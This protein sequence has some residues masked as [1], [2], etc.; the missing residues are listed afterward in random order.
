M[1]LSYL[2]FFRSLRTE[3]KQFAVIG[4]GR[5]GRAVC[6]SLH[7]MGYEALGI[8]SDEKRVAQILTDQLAAHAI[9]LD[10]T[11]VAALKEAGVFEFDTVIVAIGN[12]VEESVITTMNLKEAG[13][14]HVVAKASSEIHEKLLR[15]V[16]ADHVVFPEHEM[17]CALARS[18]TKPGILDRFELD[19]DNSIVEVIVPEDFDSKTISDLRLR[20]RFGLNLLAVSY[21]GKFEINPEPNRRLRKGE[22]MVVIGSN[23]GIDQLPI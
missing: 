10:S 12:Y 18:L 6:A 23:K 3:N 1:N 11:E 7:R 22:A 13:V 20:S 8:D 16:G 19:P 4:L 2:S 5:F 14:P 17:G 15:K 9:Q 21:N